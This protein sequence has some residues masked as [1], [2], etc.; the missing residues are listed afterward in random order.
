MSARDPT[1]LAAL[2]DDEQAQADRQAREAKQQVED[3]KWLMAH[4][5][6][7]RFV[8]RL[9]NLTGVFR[10]SMTGN[11]STF[12]NE[13]RRDIGLQLMAE[14]NDHCLDQYV[15]MLKEQAE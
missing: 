9:L 1:D 3:F 6:G 10:T 7:R 15:M 14:I 8:S 4:K 13:G 5:Q 2:A 12:F 11:S